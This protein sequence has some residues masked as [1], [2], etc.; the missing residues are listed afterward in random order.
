[1]N[2]LRVKKNLQVWVKNL[3][4]EWHDPEIRKYLILKEVVTLMGLFEYLGLGGGLFFAGAGRG[5]VS[6]IFFI[7]NG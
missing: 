4:S 3:Q 1:M 5:E 6:V 2:A 7:K